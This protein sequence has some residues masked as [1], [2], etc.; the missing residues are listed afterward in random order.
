MK[1]IGLMRLGRDPEMRHL[2]DG[3]PVMNLALA[4]NYG[5]RGQDGNRPT[6]WIE[7]A[8]FGDRAEKLA[9]YMVKGSAHCFTLSDVRIDVYDKRDG[10]GQ[11][12]K[13]AARVDDV[14]LGPRS[15]SAA[16]A[17]QQQPQAQSGNRSSAP[18][19]APQN[20]VPRTPAPATGGGSGFDD[21]D[22]D[23]PFVSCDWALEI[24]TSKAKRM[25]RYD[26]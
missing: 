13:L 19:Q 17:R 1:A 2:N 14:E 5:K 25:R 9:Q 24:E 4:V 21:M 11:G 20:P 22:D 16:P 6:Q 3:T 7:A 15:E 10:S 26:F 23:I 12:Y 18:R 8:M